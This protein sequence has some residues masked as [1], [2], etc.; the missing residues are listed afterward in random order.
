MCLVRTVKSFYRLD[1]LLGHPVSPCI[2]KG[3]A[4]KG[5]GSG[6]PETEEE[7]SVVIGA[8]HALIALRRRRCMHA[9]VQPD[10]EFLDLK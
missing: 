5:E 7:G 8:D 9:R 6:Q 10:A 4:Q 3:V 1:C 2:K